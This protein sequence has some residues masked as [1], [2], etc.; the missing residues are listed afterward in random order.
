MERATVHLGP[1]VI[2]CTVARSP[3]EHAR[4]LQGHPSLGSGEGM[5]FPFVPSR[6]GV[7]FHMGTVTFPIDIVF[8]DGDGRVA[9]IEEVEPGQPGSWGIP[10]TSYV[11]EVPRGFCRES[12]VGIGDAIAI[13][14]SSRTAQLEDEGQYPFGYKETLNEVL[15][16]S[17]PERFEDRQLP[18]EYSP[19]MP[20][21]NTHWE[22]TLG[23]SPVNE[24]SW[25]V[26]RG[27]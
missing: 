15:E 27:G 10:Q 8:V 22:E 16:G 20:Q 21:P 5:L 25:P 12:G 13:E 3:S 17:N 24:K 2:R 7:K 23:D 14:P 9:R 4:G 19:A 6:R 11:V 26:R 1:T 18:D